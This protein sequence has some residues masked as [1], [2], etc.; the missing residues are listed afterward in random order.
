[1]RKQMRRLTLA[2]VVLVTLARPAL[3][4]QGLAGGERTGVQ[5]QAVE[6]SYRSQRPYSDPFN[7]VEVDVV[8]TASDGRQWK[9]PAFWA[10]GNEWRIRF[11]PPVPGAYKYRVESTDKSNP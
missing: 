8:F 11:A 10:G 4:Q 1:M 5:N 3:A 7:Q 2:A 9:V 6:W